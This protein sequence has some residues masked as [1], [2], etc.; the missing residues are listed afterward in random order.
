MLKVRSPV[1][2]T[3]TLL[4]LPLRPP[5]PSTP[6]CS[7]INVDVS[8]L[9][10]FFIAFSLSLSLSSPL[11][12]DVVNFNAKQR[13]YR[14][15]CFASLLRQHLRDS[16]H[17]SLRYPPFGTPLERAAILTDAKRKMSNKRQSFYLSFIAWHN[18]VN[19]SSKTGKV[20]EAHTS[21][22][23]CKFNTRVSQ[24]KCNFCLYE[25]L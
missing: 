25:R 19:S 14:R 3:Q 10:A 22:I 5:C 9:C 17:P 13:E 1:A 6:L 4:P 8:I 16:S 18:A 20:S 11:L 2:N 15:I 23:P 21:Q 12:A 7:Y 24:S